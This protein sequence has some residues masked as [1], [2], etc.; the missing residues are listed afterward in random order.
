[1]DEELQPA[2]HFNLNKGRCLEVEY[3]HEA[4]VARGEE[5]LHESDE[6]G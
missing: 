1:M 4:D 3:E 5:D 2:C 6:S